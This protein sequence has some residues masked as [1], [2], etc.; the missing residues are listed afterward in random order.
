M[1]G[2]QMVLLDI[3]KLSTA[4][5]ETV[6]GEQAR[7]A[8][9]TQHAADAIQADEQL[10]KKDKVASLSSLLDVELKRL[11]D[12]HNEGGEFGAYMHGA[13]HQLLDHMKACQGEGIELCKPV[14]FASLQMV[15]LGW[16]LASAHLECQSLDRSVV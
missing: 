15:A 9:A 13:A 1:E 8:T 14:I 3:R 12:L 11:T 4:V 6:V 10:G 2:T 5:V 7:N 16:R